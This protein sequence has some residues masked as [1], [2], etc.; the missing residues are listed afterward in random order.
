MDFGM[1]QAF[2]PDG[3]AEFRKPR[4]LRF[5]ANGLLYSLAR[6]EVVLFDFGSGECRGLSRDC[7]G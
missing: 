5:A 6:D 7:R 4:G 3:K 2:A 1:H